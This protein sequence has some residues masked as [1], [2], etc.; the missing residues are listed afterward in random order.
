ML[1][2]E[3]VLLRHSPERVHKTVKPAAMH[4]VA[5]ICSSDSL[6]SSIYFG[7][8]QAEEMLGRMTKTL[9]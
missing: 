2:I 7:H 9:L 5:A 4:A 1:G 6:R 8:E 3:E